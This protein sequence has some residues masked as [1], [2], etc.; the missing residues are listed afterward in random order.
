MY[1]HEHQKDMSTLATAQM[2]STI[3][4]HKRFF[5][6]YV[7]NTLAGLDENG[8]GCVF[9]YDPIGH[10]EKKLYGATGSAGALLLPLL[11]SLVS[12]KYGNNFRLLKYSCTIYKSSE[13]YC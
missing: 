2:L 12:Y 6:Y 9:S 10:C 13:I 11:D 5:P 4:Y 1:K 8:A 3:L 7:S